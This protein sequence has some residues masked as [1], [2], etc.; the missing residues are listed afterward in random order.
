VDN[1][2]CTRQNSSLW[3]AKSWVALAKFNPSLIG[4]IKDTTV[5]DEVLPH[6][7]ECFNCR[8]N[9]L[10]SGVIMKT[11]VLIKWLDPSY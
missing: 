9:S 7:I 2:G 10:I 8:K 4:W 5:I 3:G 11:Q 1:L 6:F